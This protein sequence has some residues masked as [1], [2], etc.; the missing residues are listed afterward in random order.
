MLVYDATLMHRVRT[1]S[2]AKHG[3]MPDALQLHVAC[4][5][6]GTC[7]YNRHLW[8]ML[9]LLRSDGRAVSSAPNS[10]TLHHLLPVDLRVCRPLPAKQC[11]V[12]LMHFE[13]EIVPTVF[14]RTE[15]PESS[16]RIVG[17]D[18]SPLHAKI[19][20][21]HHLVERCSFHRHSTTSI[22][23]LCCAFAKHLPGSSARQCIY[24]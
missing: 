23:F 8:C 6:F 20:Q 1:N 5:T 24:L 10:M 12:L 9:P 3:L 22:V 13:V 15:E 14:L 2:C 19:A 16:V 18:D 11:Q 21:S 4:E 7:L 17:S